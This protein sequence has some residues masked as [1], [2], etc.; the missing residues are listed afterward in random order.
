MVAHLPTR[1]RERPPTTANLDN[2]KL[3]PTFADMEKKIKQLE[4]EA[5][6]YAKTELSNLITSVKLVCVNDGKHYFEPDF[7]D[8]PTFGIGQ[9]FFIVKERGNYRLTHEGEFERI[10]RIIFGGNG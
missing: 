3:L 10:E 2:T 7:V 1:N 9:P 6:Q 5:L 4:Q 8:S